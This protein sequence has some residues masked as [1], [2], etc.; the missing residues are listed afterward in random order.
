MPTL[1]GA[2]IYICGFLG[3]LSAYM[4]GS[5]RTIMDILGNANE[6]AIAKECMQLANTGQGDVDW[7][8]E[9]QCKTDAMDEQWQ[10]FISYVIPSLLFLFVTA[11]V[12]IVLTWFK[13]I[14][15]PGRLGALMKMA[16]ISPPKR[17]HSKPYGL[18][19]YK[20][21]IRASVYG[22]TALFILIPFVATGGKLSQSIQLGIIIL[23]FMDPLQTINESFWSSTAIPDAQVVITAGM[24]GQCT[25]SEGESNS[26]AVNLNA[27]AKLK[28]DD[29][30]L[31]TKEKVR[32]IAKQHT[33]YS[34]KVFDLSTGYYNTVKLDKMKQDSPGQASLAKSVMQELFNQRQEFMDA[35]M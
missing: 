6:D 17:D 20:R 5:W 13:Q 7:G 3:V 24:Q 2:I 34:F 15:S 14:G 31:A 26:I 21:A 11:Q 33:S 19:W 4:I 32:K 18:T 29:S 9:E 27:V 16:K 8:K 25:F 22:S 30:A 10:G 1:P 23:I 35:G 28:W 12:V